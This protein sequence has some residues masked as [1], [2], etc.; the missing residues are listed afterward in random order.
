MF[1]KIPPHLQGKVDLILDVFD[2]VTFYSR[3]MDGIEHVPETKTTILSIMQHTARILII[4]KE[5]H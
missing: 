1:I 5:S 4:L 2:D 3:V